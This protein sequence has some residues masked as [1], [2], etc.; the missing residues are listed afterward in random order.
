MNIEMIYNE[1]ED[2]HDFAPYGTHLQ[3]RAA[4]L[5]QGPS[6]KL[7]DINAMDLPPRGVFWP[8][9]D[10]SDFQSTSSPS[11]KIYFFH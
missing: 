10:Y 4:Q 8:R 5:F 2:H 7:S 6:P 1:D 9:R 11:P 3:T